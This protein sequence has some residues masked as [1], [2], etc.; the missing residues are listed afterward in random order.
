[1]ASWLPR[2][3]K[4]VVRQLTCRAAI[5]MESNRK[6]GECACFGLTDGKCFRRPIAVIRMCSLIIR[7]HAPDRT[8]TTGR[9]SR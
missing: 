7:Q 1:M 9:P 8:E 3:K 5:G 4:G 6:G 2:W